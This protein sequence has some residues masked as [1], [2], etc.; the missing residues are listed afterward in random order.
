MEL[1][2]C[3]ACAVHAHVSQTPTKSKMILKMSS[4][5]FFVIVGMMNNNKPEL[6]KKIIYFFSKKKTR[7]HIKHRKVCD[8]SQ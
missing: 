1:F 3:T 6:K 5:I 2:V 8:N 7:E 4:G